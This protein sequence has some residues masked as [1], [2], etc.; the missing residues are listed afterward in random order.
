MVM[1]KM[2]VSDCLVASRWSCGGGVKKGQKKA[3]PMRVYI[4]GQWR[5]NWINTMWHGRWL[6]GLVA[7]CFGGPANWRILGTTCQ[8]HRW[9]CVETEEHVPML[10]YESKYTVKCKS[11]V[12]HAIFVAWCKI[13][14]V[15]SWAVFDLL[16]EGSL[17]PDL[18][19][20]LNNFFLLQGFIGSVIWFWGVQTEWCKSS[21]RTFFNTTCYI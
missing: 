14:L 9:V 3:T 15:Q 11:I 20:L 19:L 4:M 12:E 8:V 18:L 16:L 1:K 5:E 7:K 6:V 21:G 10:L 13:W 17:N 2:A